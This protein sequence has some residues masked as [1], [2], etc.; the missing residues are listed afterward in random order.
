[1]TDQ[2]Q[3]PVPNVRY[4]V[5][6]KVFR[7]DTLLDPRA[8]AEPYIWAPPGLKGSAYE[9]APLDAKPV[10]PAASSAA[11][12]PGQAVQPIKADAAAKRI[13]DLEALVASGEDA[14]K[15]LQTLL[16]EERRKTADLEAQ[17]ATA[18]QRITTLEVKPVD[19][20]PANAAANATPQ[21]VKK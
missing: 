14:V 5:L 6:K 16:N 17:L 1:M 19:I 9:L 13:A 11:P 2:S 7:G 15:T 4:R 8:M 10:A 12:L 20:K 3:A 18:V 21:Q